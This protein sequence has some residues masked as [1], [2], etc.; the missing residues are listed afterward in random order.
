MQHG[1]SV[2]ELIPAPEDRSAAAFG[3][4]LARPLRKRQQAAALQGGAARRYCGSV[5]DSREAAADH[6]SY[7]AG[8]YVGSCVCMSMT[9]PYAV[10]RP[11]PPVTLMT[12]LAL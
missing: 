7:C 4:S 1:V 2:V 3:E 6:I 9:E 12:S 10:T 8:T 11:S 5:R